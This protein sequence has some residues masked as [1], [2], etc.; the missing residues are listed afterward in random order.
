[1][2]VA[3][4]KIISGDKSFIPSLATFAN[5]DSLKLYYDI[6]ELKSKIWWINI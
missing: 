2:E 4:K 6:A 1:M 5:P 3:I